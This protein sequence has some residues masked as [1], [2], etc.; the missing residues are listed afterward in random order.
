MGGKRRRQGIYIYL[1]VALM[2][3]AVVFGCTEGRNATVP[4]EGT[5]NVTPVAVELKEA[6]QLLARGDYESSL[7]T[8]R[9]IFEDYR[10]TPTAGEALYNIGIVFADP[11]NRNKDH[12]RSVESFRRLVKEYPRNPRAVE[13]G[14]WIG[15]LT[16]N[17]KLKQTASEAVKESS[18]LKQIMKESREVDKEIEEKKREENR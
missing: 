10:G 12:H 13:A 8:Y 5:N 18:R 15:I 7:K 3:F 6:R 2:M 14:I 9:K 17:A 11:E 16:E 4:S 1:F